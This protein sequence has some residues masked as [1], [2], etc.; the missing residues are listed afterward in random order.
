MAA[1]ESP[2]QRKG[3]AYEVANGEFIDNLGEKCFMAVSEEGVT[4]GIVAQ[5][6]DVN[7]ALL[8]VSKIV[9]AGNKVVFGKGESYIED[10]QTGEKMWLT[11]KDGV[12]VLDAKIAPIKEQERP[13][14]ARPGR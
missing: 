5:V 9:A 7:K 2:A 14:F 13:S 8:S 11:A 12:Y 10:G 6:C 3:V 1:R 4:R